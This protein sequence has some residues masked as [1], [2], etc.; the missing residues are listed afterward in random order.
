MVIQILAFGIVKEMVGGSS[1]GF[2]VQEGIDIKGLKQAL[3]GNFPELSGLAS[4]YI[5]V[6]NEYATPEQIIC[7]GDEIAVIPPVSGG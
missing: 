1:V 2:T 6:N 7:S 5:A 4:Y 3:E